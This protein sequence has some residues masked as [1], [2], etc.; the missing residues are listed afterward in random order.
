MPVRLMNTMWHRWGWPPVDYFTGKVDVSL[1]P[2]PLML[3]ARKK[4]I[5]TIHDLYFLEHPEDTVGEIRRDYVSLVKKHAEKADAILSVSEATKKVAME[6]LNLPAE[7]ITVCREDISPMFDEKPTDEETELLKRQYAKPYF[8]FVGTIEPR[9][10]L[11][12]LLK[13]FAMVHTRLPEME[14]IIAGYRGWKTEAFDRTIAELSCRDSIEI[15]GYCTRTMLRAL[16]HNATAL[17]M[18]SH[19]EGFGLPLLEAMASGCPVITRNISAMPEVAGDAA[20]YWE[21]EDPASLAMIMQKVAEDK[22]LQSQMRK[23]GY[24]QRQKFSWRATAE[25][26]NSVFE[27]LR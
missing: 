17:V 20:I 25:I 26:V 4:R 3:P 2:S 21:G 13:A 11:T 10:N 23:R 15:T 18:P 22:E 27:A 6:M 16:Y 12:D 19:C 9:K 7:K 14:L 5:I 1:S 8:L 24:E